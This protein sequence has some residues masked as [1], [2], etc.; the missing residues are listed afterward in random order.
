MRRRLG[1]AYAGVLADHH[2][3]VRAVLAAHGGEE[4]GSRGDEFAA[5]FASPRACAA[6]AIQAQRALASHTWPAGETVRAR[7]GIDSGEACPAAAGLA[8][9][10]VRGAAR[11]A[12]VAHGGQVLVSAATAGLL[13]DALPVGVGLTDL[14]W[15]LVAGG[16]RPQQ[17]FQLQAEGLPAGFPPP[18]SLEDPGLLTNLPAQIHQPHPG[19]QRIG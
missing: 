11:I 16:G 18:R 17:I 1:N 2:R 7:M 12:A 5:V 10:E 19:R 9:P 13:T 15:H 4:V 14:G 6:A 8:A 3:L